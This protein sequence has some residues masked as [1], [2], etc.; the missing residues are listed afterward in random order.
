MSPF[1][2]AHPKSTATGGPFREVLRHPGTQRQARRGRRAYQSDRISAGHAARIWRAAAGTSSSCSC[3]FPHAPALVAGQLD[4]LVNNSVAFSSPE[5]I[6]GPSVGRLIPGFQYSYGR[7]SAPTLIDGDPAIG[8][9]FLAAYFH[10]V[11]DFRAGS[12]PQAF[13]GIAI[14]SGMDPGRARGLPAPFDRGWLD[15]SFLRPAHDRLV[16]KKR[17]LGTPRSISGH[18]QPVRREVGKGE[19]VRSFAWRCWLPVAL[20]AVWQTAS[21]AG[22]LN[23]LFFPAPWKLLLA[24]VKMSPELA[25]NTGVTLARTAAGFLIGSALGLVMG[26]LMG[27]RPRIRWSLEPLVSAGNATPKLTLLPLL[28]LLFGVGETARLTLIALST[29]IIT[30]IYAFEAVR[31]IHPARVELA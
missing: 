1:P 4:A 26:L 12:V 19:I 31:N 2:A 18:R 23:P 7:S 27:A 9:A 3:A 5:I 30:S 21:S 11:R 8:A 20:L 28:M 29:L 6:A 13:D 24:A 10:G 14:R 22:L 25:V 17:F 15:R 16:G